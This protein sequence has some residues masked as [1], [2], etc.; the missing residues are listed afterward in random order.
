MGTALYILDK[1]ALFA[2]A[3]FAMKS[4]ECLLSIKDGLWRRIVLISAYTLIITMVIFVGDRDNL[5][6]T[7]ILFH[8]CC[9]DLLQRVQTA[10]FHHRTHVLQHHAGIQRVL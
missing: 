5:P 10:A 3:Y 7:V 1:L 8:D 9:H 2:A 4:S 6:P